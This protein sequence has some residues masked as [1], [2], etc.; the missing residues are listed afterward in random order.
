MPV[1][2]WGLRSLSYMIVKNTVMCVLA[3]VFTP[4]INITP[5]RE[6]RRTH[7]LGISHSPLTPGNY[8]SDFYHSKLVLPLGKWNHKVGTLLCLVSFPQPNVFEILLCG[9]LNQC[10]HVY[11][12]VG[13][14]VLDIPI[15]PFLMWEGNYWT[16][17]VL[18]LLSFAILTAVSKWTHCSATRA[19]RA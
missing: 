13:F 19:V 2:S 5:P 14:S 4:V 8:W 9:C 1:G 7:L 18:D 15:N 6:F 17:V 10:V 3:N 11:Y 16:A 12:W